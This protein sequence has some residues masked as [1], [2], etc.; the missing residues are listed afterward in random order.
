M[1]VI[2]LGT[3]AGGGFPQWNCACALCA[4]GRRGELPARSQECVAV[5]GDGRD[6]W[7]LNA[8]PDIRTQ[9][10]AAPAL[11]PGPGPR[12]TPVRGVL[13]TDA[14]VDHALGLA[15]LRGATGLTVY[16]APPV[17]GA[18]SA[19]LPVRGLL[20]RYAPWD[21]RDATAPGG[22]AV[23]GGLTVTAHPVGTKAPKYAHAPDPDAPWVCAYRIE[24]PATG[25]ALVYA[26]CLATWPDGFDDLLASATCALLDGTFFSAG[27]L[28]TATSS[29]GAGQSLMGHL[30]V[31][32]PGGSLAALAR[33][34]GLRRIY[35]HLNNTN[36]LL[37]PSSAAHAAVRE[38][39]VEVLPDGSEL[40]L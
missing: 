27:E 14:E 12:D 24:D 20:D 40:V 22:F 38:A 7:L 15:V 29:A 1:K 17:R 26:P 18:L 35:T 4:R 25:G 3:A 28:G 11:T 32:G 13:L 5:S 34:R 9:L 16:A 30:P 2:L 23:A 10:L 36:P 19:E 21:W 8:S 39:G 6:W 31:A 37:D 33:H